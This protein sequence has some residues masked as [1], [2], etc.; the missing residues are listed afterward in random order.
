M[1]ILIQGPPGIGKTTLIVKLAKFLKNPKGFYT[2]E[3]RN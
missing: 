3:I 2:Q 1:N